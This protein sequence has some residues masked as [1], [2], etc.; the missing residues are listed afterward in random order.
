M[1]LILPKMTICNNL[2]TIIRHKDHLPHEEGVSKAYV[3]E[4]SFFSHCTYHMDKISILSFIGT[5]HPVPIALPD[6]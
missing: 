1:G 5:G 4:T 6:T 3:F 2:M